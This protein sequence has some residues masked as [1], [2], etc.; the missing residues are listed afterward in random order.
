[1]SENILQFF[2]GNQSYVEIFKTSFGTAL[3]III[4]ISLLVQLIVNYAERCYR[5]VLTVMDIQD[6]FVEYLL[7]HLR[8][9]A[10]NNIFDFVLDRL[11]LYHRYRKVKDIGYGEGIPLFFS[12]LIIF[13]YPQDL[14]SDEWVGI[15]VFTL[16]VI[17][18]LWSITR[19][20]I[21]A[22]R[23]KQLEAAGSTC[24][25]EKRFDD[26]LHFYRQALSV[27]NQPWIISNRALDQER[28]DLL[29]QIALIL[30]NRRHFEEALIHYRR[31]LTLYNRDTLAKDQSLDHTRER[32]LHQIAKLF[33]RLGNRREARECC[34][35]IY[36]QTGKRYVL[37][38]N[39]Y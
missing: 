15:T 36:D 20:T 17:E 29:E 13:L 27:Y 10:I 8:K 2:F 16:L 28:A 24:Y 5:W 37:S 12:V 32:L 9:L 1:M 25:Q 34:Q 30:N 33:Y 31:A 7:K 21:A 39:F 26:S 19:L 23:A 11:E 18:K 14:L 4:L 38:G 22:H 3:F 6:D 35:L